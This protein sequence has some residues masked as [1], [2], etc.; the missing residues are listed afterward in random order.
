M[1]A[2]FYDIY[3]SV[4]IYFQIGPGHSDCKNF[5][6]SRHLT[7]HKVPSLVIT[8]RLEETTAMTY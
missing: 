6:Y 3:A 7:L 2:S 5:R 4:L 8:V 1:S